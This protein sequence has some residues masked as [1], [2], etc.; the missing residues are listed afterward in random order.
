MDGIPNKVYRHKGKAT[1]ALPYFL[2]KVIVMITKADMRN[3]R[4]HGT[5]VLAID[6]NLLPVG[7]LVGVIMFDD[8]RPDYIIL[9]RKVL[10]SE[11]G[12][13]TLG[14]A[15]RLSS[16]QIDCDECGAI[17]W[18][19]FDEIAPDGVSLTDNVNAI[20]YWGLSSVGYAFAIGGSNA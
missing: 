1:M 9:G 10:R 11:S 18:E 13:R 3:A 15:E 12:C 2:G 20:S 5:C 4:E 6:T 7:E 19:L 16:S 14:H 17:C 8:L